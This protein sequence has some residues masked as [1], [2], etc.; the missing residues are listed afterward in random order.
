[1]IKNKVLNIKIIFKILK[2]VKN[3]LGFQA[4]FYSLKTS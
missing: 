2:Y 1:M 4:N 3:N